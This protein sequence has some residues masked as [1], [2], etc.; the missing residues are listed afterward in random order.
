V[1]EQIARNKW[2]SVL[3]VFL[4]LLL[5]AGLGFVFGLLFDA[6][7][8][9]IVLA[10]IIAAVM[11]WSSYRYGDRLVLR[12][13]RARP[14]SPEEYPRYH[15]IVEGLC[16]AA[17]IPKPALYVIPEKA[18]NAF[19]TGRDPE[20]A[21]IAVTEGLLEMMNRVELEGVLAHELAHVRNRDILVGTLVATLV[22]VVAL[23]AD[24]MLRAF[25][26]GG[27]RG[28]RGDRGGGG[29]SV[30]AIIAIVGLVL[31]ALAP[32]FAQLI[33]FAV[34]RRREL[35]ADADGALL[36]RYPP[37][38]ASALRKIAASTE[39]LRAS[40]NATAHLWFSQPSRTAGT[41]WTR[42]ERLFSTHPPVEERV[43][44]LEA[45]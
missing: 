1:Y 19:A 25:F 21:S 16:I 11:S 42:W 32:L 5:A 31:A 3:L 4:V 17:G 28:R 36:S 24:W 29:G 38:L 33:R 6:G 34:S 8:F 18:P 37:G 45:M 30:G 2:R 13:S 7:P 9:G 10:L 20:H 27:F 40:N 35:L 23:L 14:A 15:N 12:V 43:K 44:A 22:G 41:G 39:P 26:W